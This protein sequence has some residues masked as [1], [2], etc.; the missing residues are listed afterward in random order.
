[1]KRCLH[2]PG[3]PFAKFHLSGGPAYETQASQAAITVRGDVITSLRGDVIASPLALAL[4]EEH[5]STPIV[6]DVETEV[7]P[8]QMRTEIDRGGSLWM[9]AQEG[10]K[11]R[12]MQ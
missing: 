7:H 3:S 5:P 8:R 11:Q 6:W 10:D 1:M 4:Y 9:P 2:S 12:K